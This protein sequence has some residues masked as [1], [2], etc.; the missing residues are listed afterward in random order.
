MKASSAGASG[1]LCAHARARKERLQWNVE[2]EKRHCVK[3]INHFLYGTNPYFSPPSE[4]PQEVLGLQRWWTP[5]GWEERSHT[6][7]TAGCWV[8]PL[9]QGP[10]AHL[11][12][13]LEEMSLWPC[14]EESRHKPDHWLSTESLL[15]CWSPLRGQRGESMAE[16]F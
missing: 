8:P 6:G 1:C 12:N 4:S 15:N 11:R 16:K 7:R 2:E 9:P 3:R 10:A 5:L 13:L 14:P